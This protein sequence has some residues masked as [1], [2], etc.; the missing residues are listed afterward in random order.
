MNEICPFL[1]TLGINK[2]ISLVRC[3]SD[4]ALN[5]GVDCALKIL[6]VSALRNMRSSNEQSN[7]KLPA[8]QPE[9]D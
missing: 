2:D 7:K 1:S 3:R 8:E 9:K 6:G 5:L 4:C